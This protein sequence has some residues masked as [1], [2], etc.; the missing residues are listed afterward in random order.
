MPAIIAIIHELF[1]KSLAK[2]NNSLAGFGEYIYCLNLSFMKLLL[3]EAKTRML[4]HYAGKGQ[5]YNTLDRYNRNLL[6]FIAMVGDIDVS[7]I[8]SFMIDDYRLQ[9]VKD[10]AKD[11]TINHEL[12]ILRAL[13]NFVAKFYSDVR[14]INATQIELAKLSKKRILIIPTKEEVKKMIEA[15]DAT[16]LAGLRDR[17][18]MSLLASSGVRVKELTNLNKINVD[19][20]T[21]ILQV[22]SGKGNKDRHCIFS[23]E[24]SSY[25]IE[26]LKKR[27]SDPLPALFISLSNHHNDERKV[28]NIGRLSTVSVEALVKKYARL[29]G[30]RK[31][32]TPHTL[33]HFFASTTRPFVDTKE[34]QEL[35]G[36]ESLATTDIYTHKLP[37][38]I[39]QIRK[40]MQSANC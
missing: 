10:G 37:G 13:F 33:R 24:A 2:P 7:R 3:S 4:S 22:L 25:L 38:F 39:E 28:E 15:A 35:L 8:T 18:I 34:L 36:H 19:F 21:G 14:C 26:Y 12:S 32:V 30:I 23:N 31:K 17:A 5:S 40:K 1:I 11:V 6:R 27:G 16:T 20:D 9:R 29:A